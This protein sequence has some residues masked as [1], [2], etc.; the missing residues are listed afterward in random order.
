MVQEVLDQ[1]CLGKFWRGSKSSLALVGRLHDLGDNRS[2]DF[3][4]EWIEAFFSRIPAV[5]Q[6]EIIGPD[7]VTGKTLTLVF[8]LL[9]LG[10]VGLCD[11]GKEL[12]PGGA[13][14]SGPGRIVGST[15]KRFAIRC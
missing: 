6:A 9:S 4:P 3:L 10:L 15:E 5:F 1:E 2:Q 12:N 11:A 8:D 13:I 14:E 7:N